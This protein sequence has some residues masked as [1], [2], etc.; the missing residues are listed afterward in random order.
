MSIDARQDIE[1]VR[2]LLDNLIELADEAIEDGSSIDPQE[3]KEIISQI[4]EILAD[5]FEN[6]FGGWATGEEEEEFY[7]GEDMEE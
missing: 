3:I 4:G 7:D 6:D 2:R 1:T 5:L